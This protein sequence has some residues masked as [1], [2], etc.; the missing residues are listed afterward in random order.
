MK[1]FAVVTAMVFM[2]AC[3][4]SAH[5]SHN[6]KI[7]G[8]NVHQVSN[9]ST[10]NRT[11]NFYEVFP[12]NIPGN[13]W[14]SW[15]RT[16]AGPAW[17]AHAR[18]IVPTGSAMDLGEVYP[19]CVY[20]LNGDA[21]ICSASS[22]NVPPQWGGIAEYFVRTNGHIYEARV[23]LD[24]NGNGM[25]APGNVCYFNNTV[26]AT[27]G[28]S[29]PASTN[30]GWAADATL[31]HEM[32]HIFGLA[33]PVIG[34]NPEPSPMGHTYTWNGTE[35]C[36][37]NTPP[38]GTGHACTVPYP[39]DNAQISTSSGHV[40]AG[41]PVAGGTPAAQGTTVPA[42]EAS[43]FLDLATVPR[44][45]QF[46]GINKRVGAITPPGVERAE[47][48]WTKDGAED[49]VHVRWI[50]PVARISKEKSKIGDVHPAFREQVRQERLANP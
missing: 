49:V 11:V 21:N 32:G 2:L 3:A 23:R 46:H 34:V 16:E 1:Y 45:G 25:A 33:H 9:A 48:R 7:N 18:L 17:N 8:I 20:K 22:W 36:S 39:H 47:A 38:P 41:G 37:Y 19:S 12:S 31:H 15:L 35:G 4:T 26:D 13:Q 43:D 29:R 24:D 44:D 10:T 6:I 42:N 30:C 28:A 14:S 50:L 5:A 27:T 40:D